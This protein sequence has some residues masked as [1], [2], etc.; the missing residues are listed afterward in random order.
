MATQNI[1]SITRSWLSIN[2][3]DGL[4]DTEGRCGCYFKESPNRCRYTMQCQPAYKHECEHCIDKC[5][6]E[7]LGRGCF[8]V[9][10]QEFGSSEKGFKPFKFMSEWIEP[11]DF[12]LI[13]FFKYGYAYSTFCFKDK[14]TFDDLVNVLKV[15]VDIFEKQQE[16]K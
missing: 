2:G 11:Q 15:I 5:V 7:H 8:K 10:K 16:G 4:C 13:T 1:E 3:Y 9:F 12:G 14:T 6:N